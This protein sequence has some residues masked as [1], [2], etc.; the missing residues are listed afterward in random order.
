[1]PLTGM[2]LNTHVTPCTDDFGQICPCFVAAVLPNQLGVVVLAIVQRNIVTA[3]V[4]A[5]LVGASRGAALELKIHLCEGEANLVALGSL[6]GGIAV[7]VIFVAGIG[8]RLLMSLAAVTVVARVVAGLFVLGAVDPLSLIVVD[9]A[10]GISVHR[11]RGADTQPPNIEMICHVEVDVESRVL[12]LTRNLE[13]V[14]CRVRLEPNGDAVTRTVNG[15]WLFVARVDAE[16]LGLDGRPIIYFD[17]VATNTPVCLLTQFARLQINL[18]DL[19]CDSFS[20]FD[21]EGLDAIQVVAVAIVLPGAVA[22]ARGTVNALSPVGLVVVKGADVVAGDA[23]PWLTNVHIHST[24]GGILERTPLRLP[25]LHDRI[26]G[27]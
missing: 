15:R 12:V 19:Q 4:G 2:K 8:A 10:M 20:T 17:H 13:G 16:A 9:R 22:C 1:M 5:P 3:T 23:V 14:I 21:G 24:V 27:R 18:A 25:H 11:R 26:G 7:R 6:D